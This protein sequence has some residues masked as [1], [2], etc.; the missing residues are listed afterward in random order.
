MYATH[1]GH[2][3]SA[4][5]LVSGLRTALESRHTIGVAQGILMRDYD[6]DVAS[7]FTLLTRYSSRLNVKL[8][9]LA[10]QVVENGGLPV[11]PSDQ[12]DAPTA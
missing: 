6:I 3:V 5:C 8:R 2:A 9:V 4:T 7:A 1:A 10:E 11:E 12:E